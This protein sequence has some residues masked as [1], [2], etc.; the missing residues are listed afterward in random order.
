MKITYFT[1]RWVTGF[2]FW[3]WMKLGNYKWKNQSYYLH[4]H[5]Y[6]MHNKYL[7]INKYLLLII[8]LLLFIYYY[9]LLLFYY[10]IISLIIN[11]K[12]SWLQ[13]WQVHTNFLHL[14]ILISLHCISSE[15]HNLWVFFFPVIFSTQ[16]NCCGPRHS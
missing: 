16:N 13:L 9:Y 12:N 11:F 10:F 7:K 14:L 2:L 5:N 6:D 8:I 4:I 1:L 15:T 3:V